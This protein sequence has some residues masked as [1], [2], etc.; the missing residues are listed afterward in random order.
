MDDRQYFDSHFDG[1]QPCCYFCTGLHA[2]AI[3]A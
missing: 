3:F 2:A 1:L